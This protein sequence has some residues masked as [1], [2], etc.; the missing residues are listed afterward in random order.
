MITYVPLEIR[1][2]D[3]QIE[4]PLLDMVNGL[5]SKGGGDVIVSTHPLTQVGVGDLTPPPWIGRIFKLKIFRH[6]LLIL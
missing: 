1:A 5:S 3:L 6:T 4:V 2:N